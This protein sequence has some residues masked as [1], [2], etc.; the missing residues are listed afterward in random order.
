[1]PQKYLIQKS[2]SC[3][4]CGAGW[5]TLDDG[6]QRGNITELM[7]TSQKSNHVLVLLI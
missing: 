7:L 6:N 4:S 2:T 5:P 3:G 1:M